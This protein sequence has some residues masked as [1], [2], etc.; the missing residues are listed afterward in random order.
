MSLLLVFI[1]CLCTVQVFADD[2]KYAARSGYEVYIDYTPIDFYIIN[3]LTYIEVEDLVN[4]GFTVDFDETAQSYNVSRIKFATPMYTREMWEEQT[5]MKTGASIEDSNIKVYLDGQL[6]NSYCAGGKTLVQFD[7]LQKYGEVKWNEY[8]G[9]LN[10]YIFREELQSELDNAENVVEIEFEGGTYKGQVDEN[11]LPHGIGRWEDTDNWEKEFIYMGYFTHSKPDGLM[12]KET[13]RTVS[14]TY[15]MRYTYFIGKVDGSK[16][17]EREYEEI[18][19]YNDGY[20][21]WHLVSRDT[22]FGVSCLPISEIPTASGYDTFYDETIYTEGCYYEYKYGQFGTGDYRIWHNGKDKQF[23]TDLSYG[24]GEP[25]ELIKSIR[26]TNDKAETVTNYFEY[27]NGI[28]EMYTGAVQTISKIGNDVVLNA[29]IDGGG[30]F[31]T[32]LLNNEGLIFDVLPVKQNDRVLVPV[33]AIAEALGAKVSWDNDTWTADIVKDGK[34][35]TLQ[36]GN[37]VMK[38]DDREITLDVAPKIIDGRT[39]VPVRA[40]SEAFEAKVDWNNELQQVIIK[41]N[42]KGLPL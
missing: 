41:T 17:A 12:Y 30:R 27:T 32:V 40:V 37:N 10:V 7:E 13:Y 1:M 18:E 34:T 14:H 9:I 25:R 5:G 11:N 19:P 28:L 31:I 35:I 16:K 20:V 42:L 4:Y 23:I 21:Y 36:I 33:R 2:V 15:C 6:A 8:S 22:N 38:I 26:K 29:P 24:I 39:M 3:D